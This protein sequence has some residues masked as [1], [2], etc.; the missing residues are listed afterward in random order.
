MDAALKML[1]SALLLSGAYHIRIAENDPDFD[2]IRKD[3]RFHELVAA[4][5]KRHKIDQPAPQAAPQ[6]SR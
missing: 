5:K 4:A 1:Q 6:L 2:N 3:S